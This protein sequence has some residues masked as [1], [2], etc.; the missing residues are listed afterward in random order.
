[1][2]THVHIWKEG[3]WSVFGLKEL[4]VNQ[5][6]MPQRTKLTLLTHLLSLFMK[7]C[8]CSL[9]LL[10]L[11]VTVLSH[12]VT[13]LFSTHSRRHIPPD[14]RVCSRDSAKWARSDDSMSPFVF[15]SGREFTLE[16][17]VVGI[18]AQNFPSLFSV[19]TRKCTSPLMHSLTSHNLE[20]MESFINV[21]QRETAS[22]DRLVHAHKHGAVSFQRSPQRRK[23]KNNNR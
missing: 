17:E 15:T 23:G 12:T 4:V 6:V 21:A 20:V 11:S 16:L 10:H 2:R 19:S 14:S 9:S 18:S 7:T 8:V 3:S 5:P 13:V 22:A 1:M